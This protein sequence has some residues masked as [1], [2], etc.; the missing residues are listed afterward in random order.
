MPHAGATRSLDRYS[1][2]I[3]ADVAGP[4]AVTA[5][6]YYQSIEAIAA[7]KLLGNLADTDQ[8]FRLEPCVLGGL[9]DGRVP[10]V[11]PAV[12]EGSPPVPMEVRNWVIDVGGV[13]ASQ[14]QRAPAISTYPPPDATA[15]FRDA[16]VKAFLSEPITGLDRSTFTLQDS[17]GALVPATVDQIGDGAWALFP[18]RVFLKPGEVYQAHIDG[19]LCE[20]LI[21]CTTV[22]RLALHDGIEG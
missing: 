3:P 9:C 7:L 21:C 6:V 13:S 11:E 20:F 18:D 17:R 15:V 4:V 10:S 16:V 12:V 5:A 1:V 19:R 8:D 22:R 14:S 2:V